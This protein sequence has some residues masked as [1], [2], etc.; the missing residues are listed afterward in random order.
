MSEADALNCIFAEL[1]KINKVAVSRN[2]A[3]EFL[4]LT[5]LHALQQPL[6]QTYA[7]WSLK[8]DSGPFRSV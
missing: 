8:I 6:T 4:T 5:T 7:P 3:V 2:S 1:C